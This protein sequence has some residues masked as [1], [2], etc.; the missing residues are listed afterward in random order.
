MTGDAG[1]SEVELVRRYLRAATGGALDEA[2]ELLAPDVVVR[3]P[4]GVLDGVDAVRAFWKKP[5]P[6]HLEVAMDEPR[7]RPD[8]EEVL[9]ESREVARWKDGGEVAYVT[10]YEARFRVSDGRI[11]ATTLTATPD[12]DGS[13]HGTR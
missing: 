4:R 12:P 3:T 7:Y 9:V 8:G 6:E 10:R 2:C 11:T 1:A 5:P 13:G